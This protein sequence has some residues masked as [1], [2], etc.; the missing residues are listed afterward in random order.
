P[1]CPAPTEPPEFDEE[2]APPPG[3]VPDEEHAPAN[4]AATVMRTM[5]RIGMATFPPS[6]PTMGMLDEPSGTCSGVR[7]TRPIRS[8]AR[9]S[10]IS[11]AVSFA[12]NFRDGFRAILAP[13]ALRSAMAANCG[14]AE[15]GKT[16]RALLLPMAAPVIAV[17]LAPHAER[18]DCDA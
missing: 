15:R 7:L 10:S 17:A 1:P 4:A 14:E 16:R 18:H 13:R 3:F 5:R 6:S 2:P 9:R 12:S 11:Q 8:K